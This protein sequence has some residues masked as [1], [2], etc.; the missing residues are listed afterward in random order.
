[1]K[2]LFDSRDQEVNSAEKKPHKCVQCS[3]A[4]YR[5]DRLEQHMRVHTG[6]KPFS[7]SLCI[8]SF[9]RSDSLKKHLIAHTEELK[10]GTGTLSGR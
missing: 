3:K 1:M 6:E 5:I 4:F 9:C 10:N 8:K 2:P 7:C